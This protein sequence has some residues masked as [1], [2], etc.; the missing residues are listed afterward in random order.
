MYKLVLYV[1]E[2]GLEDVKSAVFKAG[3]GCLGHYDSCSWQV[4]GEGQFRPLAGSTP[5]LGTEG[6]LETVPEWRLE[7]LVGEDVLAEVV[8]VMKAAH[9]YEEPA[10]E[11]YQC[12]DV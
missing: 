6:E 4:F 7:V 8:A 12:I 10:Y 11:V 1:P 5:Y 2:N 9:P 3:A